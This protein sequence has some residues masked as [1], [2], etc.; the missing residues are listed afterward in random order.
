MEPYP[1][2]EQ[3]QFLTARAGPG[4]LHPKQTKARDGSLSPGPSLLFQNPSKASQSSRD[5]L[6]SGVHSWGS[7]AEARS[8]SWNMVLARGRPTDAPSYF[9]GTTPTC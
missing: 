6:S 5:A 3:E 2:L 7:Q 9:N 8:S 1:N 4:P